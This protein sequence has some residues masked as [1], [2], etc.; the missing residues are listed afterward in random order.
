MNKSELVDS[1]AQSAG[2]TKSKLQKQSMHSPKA[3]KAHY[4]A[5]M[6]LYW[7]ALALSV[8]KSVKL[9]LAVTLRLEKKSKSL[10]A[11]YLALKQVKA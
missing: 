4:N 7:L 11:K 9:V 2:L 6:M 3:Y 5:V 1:I 8:S 10:P